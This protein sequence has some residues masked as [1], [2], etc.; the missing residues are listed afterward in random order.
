MSRIGNA[1]IT[2][3][4]EV[5]VTQEGNVLVVKGAKG[6]LRFGVP[7]GIAIGING[8]IIEVTRKHNDKPTRALHGAMR[9]NIANMIVGVTT[10]WTRVLE[11][12]GVGYRANLSGANLVLSVGFSH[13]VTIAPPAGITFTAADGKIT[14]AGIDK[15]QVGQVAS[16]IRDVKKPEPYKGKGI[17]YEG[18]RI[19]KKAGKAKAVGGAPG[20]K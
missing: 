1:P 12:S 18:E 6:E 3:P 15:Q 5:T 16:D 11:L 14:V 7:M 4:K 8:E 2:V 19:R 10:G 13:Q 9:A 20:A 17:K